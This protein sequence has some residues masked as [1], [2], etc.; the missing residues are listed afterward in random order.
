MPEITNRND[1]M[2]KKKLK[3]KKT[4]HVLHSRN[5]YIMTGVIILTPSNADGRSCEIVD[6]TTLGPEPVQTPTAV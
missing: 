1:V 3:K 6:T 2:P 4:V 5:S